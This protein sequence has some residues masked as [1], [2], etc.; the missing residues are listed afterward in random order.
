MIYSLTLNRNIRVRE[1]SSAFDLS[2][3]SFSE[4]FSL[5]LLIITVCIVGYA[6]IRLLSLPFER[7]EGEYAYIAQLILQGIAPFKAA[8]TMKLPGTPLMYALSML[9]FGQSIIG[10]HIGILL[11]SLGSI[12]LTFFL[13]KRWLH[14]IIGASFA[15][16]FFAI[17]SFSPTTLGF[18]GHATHFVIFFALAGILTLESAL[19]NKCSSYFFFAGLFF[20]L[21]FLMKQPGIFFTAFASALMLLHFFTKKITGKQLFRASAFF[22][23][24][25]AIPL[26]LLIIILLLASDFFQ[27]LVLDYPLQYA[28]RKTAEFYRW[29]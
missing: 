12:T 2:K 24:A 28:I 11:I 18:A 14:S 22:F 20:S 3:P 16:S 29:L 5:F 21:S 1:K 13:A 26:L 4:L 8:F 10:V 19:E 23:I 25:F 6:R 9:L 27:F 7:D 17:A 15:A